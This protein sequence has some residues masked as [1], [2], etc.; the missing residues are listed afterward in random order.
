VPFS[1]STKPPIFTDFIFE[2]KFLYL[3]GSDGIE[4]MVRQQYLPCSGWNCSIDVVLDHPNDVV[5][6]R[7]EN[8]IHDPPIIS[9]S[10]SH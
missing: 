4:F 2:A 6:Y 9:V 1:G 5:A 7:W 3:S 10:I 8:A